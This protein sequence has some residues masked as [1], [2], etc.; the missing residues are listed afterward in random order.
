LLSPPFPDYG[1][2]LRFLGSAESRRIGSR[3]TGSLTAVFETL[4]T[5]CTVFTTRI[6]LRL[7]SVPNWTRLHLDWRTCDSLDPVY[8]PRLTFGHQTLP[9]SS[10]PSVIP[11]LRFSSR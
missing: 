8:I 2:L 11:L 7:R 4:I 3:S 1:F 6:E 5:L 10:G 9:P